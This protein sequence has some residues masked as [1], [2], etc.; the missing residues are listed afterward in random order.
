MVNKPQQPAVTLRDGFISAAIWQNS[1]DN[2]TFYAVTFTRAYKD[3][4]KLQNTSSFSGTDLLKLARLA[5]KSYDKVRE[6]AADN[7]HEENSQAPENARS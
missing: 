6:L 3:G 4:D 5:E 1:N 2:G 7:G